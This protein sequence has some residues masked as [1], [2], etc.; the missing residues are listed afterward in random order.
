MGARRVA[1]G[2]L[3]RTRG[4]G[5]RHRVLFVSTLD[6]VERWTRENVIAR[7][8]RAKR[9]SGWT[10]EV[11]HRVVDLPVAG[12]ARATA[13][14]AVLLSLTEAERADRGVSRFAETA[15]PPRSGDSFHTSV[16]DFRRRSV[17]PPEPAVLQ[18]SSLR[19]GGLAVLAGTASRRS[20]KRIA[21]PAGRLGTRQRAPTLL[22]SRMRAARRQLQTFSR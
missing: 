12:L 5:Q 14:S 21:P 13:A 22:R 2:R 6:I 9:C 20:R 1:A 15:T 8:V 3:A 4:L 10:A 19:S 18:G 7:W 17:T 11:E 16:G